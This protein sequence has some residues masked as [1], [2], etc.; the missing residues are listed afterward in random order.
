MIKTIKLRK[1]KNLFSFKSFVLE[2]NMDFLMTKNIGYVYLKYY[3]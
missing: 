2:S 1:N 3:Y